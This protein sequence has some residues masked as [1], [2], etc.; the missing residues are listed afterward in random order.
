MGGRESILCSELP[1]CELGRN[2][3]AQR[4]RADVIVLRSYEDDHGITILDPPD[5]DNVEKQSET[6][7]DLALDPENLFQFLS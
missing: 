7:P 6:H 1:S 2:R 4:V 3:F 5:Y